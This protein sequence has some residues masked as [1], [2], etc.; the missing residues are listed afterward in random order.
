MVKNSVCIQ[1]IVMNFSRKINH[2]FLK[3]KMVACFC[4]K[5]KLQIETGLN[6]YILSTIKYFNN[7]IIKGFLT[8]IEK[9]KHRIEFTVNLLKK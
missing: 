6:T 9:C 3:I 5:Q 7:V 1:F 2:I 4:A 8:F